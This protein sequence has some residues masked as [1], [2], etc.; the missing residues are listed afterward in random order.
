MGQLH[1]VNTGGCRGAKVPSKKFWSQLV[2]LN[3]VLDPFI[4]F[5]SFSLTPFFSIFHSF[6]Q[7]LFS[8]KLVFIKLFKNVYFW[9]QNFQFIS[10]FQFLA[11]KLPIFG[12]KNFQ[13]LTSF[14]FLATKLPIFGNKTSNFWQQKFQFISS[15]QFLATKLPIFGDKTTNFFQLSI[16][17][18][19]T[20]HSFPTSIFGKKTSNS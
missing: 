14:Q 10:S 11:T 13:F 9:Q 15:L 7:Q 8:S 5:F 20:S 12:K 3:A 6:P 16:F 1:A 17:G 4:S 2:Y 19:K 18:D